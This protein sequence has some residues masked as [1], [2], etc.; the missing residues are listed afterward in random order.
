[1][2]CK[3]KNSCIGL[4]VAKAIAEAH[5]GKI[6]AESTDGKSILFTVS[7]KNIQNQDKKSHSL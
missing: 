4:S 1:M 3:M 2:V 6:S 5:G 7:L